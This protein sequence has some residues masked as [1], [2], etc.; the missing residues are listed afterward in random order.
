MKRC[1]RNN[2]RAAGIFHGLREPAGP[3]LD[4]VPANLAGNR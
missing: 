2:E 3:A 1:R 4:T